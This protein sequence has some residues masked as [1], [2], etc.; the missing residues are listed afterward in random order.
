MDLL[1][2]GTSAPLTLTLAVLRAD[3]FHL[4]IG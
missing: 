2:V 1:D 3:A 4:M